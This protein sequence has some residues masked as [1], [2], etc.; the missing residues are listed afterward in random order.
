V[1]TKLMILAIKLVMKQKNG[2]LQV[3]I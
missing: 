3:A 1:D 2:D